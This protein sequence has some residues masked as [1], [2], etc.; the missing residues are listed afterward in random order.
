[1]SLPLVNQIR[2]ARSEFVRGLQGVSE[3][4]GLRRFVPINSIGWMV[5]HMASHEQRFWLWRAQ[6]IVLMPDIDEAVGYGK[7]AST[8]ALGAMWDA[9]HAITA[10]VDPWLDSLTTD[11]L[12][13]RL[14][15]GGKEH[16]ET[17]GSMLQRTMYHY[18]FHTGES[19]AVR[20]LL[21]HTG[22][23]EYVGALGVE[24]PYESESSPR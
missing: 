3:E 1:M 10:A 20:Q 2:F 14:I 12:P 6:G 16:D 24:A 23:P 15:V 13:S 17:I 9:W 4:E 19:Q 8:P 5:G 7:P 18:W 11:H 22:L 21:G